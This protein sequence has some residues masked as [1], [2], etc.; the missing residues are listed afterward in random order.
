VICAALADGESVIENFGRSDDVDATLNG[1]R[2]LGFADSFQE[3]NVLRIRPRR[4]T[5]PRSRGSAKEVDC[6]E[7][8]STLRFLLPIAALGQ[9]IDAEPAVFKGRGRLFERP[10]EV[11]SKIFTEFAKAG[12]EFIQEFDR[13]IVKGPLKNGEFVLPGDVSSQF[14]SGMLLALPL[15]DGDSEIR[16]STP[17]ESGKYVEMTVEVMKSFGV[18]IEASERSYFVRGGQGY[19]AARYKIEADYSQAAFFLAAA[20][21]GRDVRVSGLNPDSVQ[22]DAAM[23]RVL[24][25][26]GAEVTWKDGVVS[27]RADTL[28]AVTVDARE[29]P[30]LIPPIASLCCFCQGTSE[31]VNAGR[32]RLKESDRLSAL[33]AE[34]GKLGAKIVETDRSLSIT[35][36]ERLKGG[37]VDAWGDHRVAMAM[38]VAAVRCDGPVSLTGWQSV[39]KSY[40]G[41]WRDFEGAADERLG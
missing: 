25:G 3:E 24:R 1:V 6:G 4:G 7:S 38:A 23:L 12:S 8:G 37:K 14:I 18:D 28:S 5:E 29:I 40:P 20:A 27:V 19:R 13:V 15:L 2:S 41:F 11:Y 9:N 26:M 30:D 36:A 39:N 31:I 35:G 21:L 34:L 32:L 22:G 17:L 33:A 16:L 10:L